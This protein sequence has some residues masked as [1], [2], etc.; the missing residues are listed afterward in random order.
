MTSSFDCHVERLS[1]NRSLRALLVA[2]LKE[3][4]WSACGHYH[5]LHTPVDNFKLF[6]PESVFE[7]MSTETNRYPE[8]FFDRP[9]ELSPQSCFSKWKPTTKQEGLHGIA[10]R[11]RTLT[12]VIIE[13]N[14]PHLGFLWAGLDWWCHTID[15]FCC[16]FLHFCDNEKKLQKSELEYNPL[17][18]IQPLL[19]L[20]LPTYR[21][22]C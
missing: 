16:S 15:L 10:N 11:D 2:R 8:H 20:T 3:T 12:G 17:Y 7:L 14:G 22:V 18:K 21:Q 6:F 5:W 1:K 9:S 4:M 19:D 13:N